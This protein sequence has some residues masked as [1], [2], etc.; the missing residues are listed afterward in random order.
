MLA[1]TAQVRTTALGKDSFQEADITGITMPVTKHNYLVK[2]VNDLPRVVA[3]ALYIAGT[4]RPGPVLIDVPMDVSLAEIDYQPVKEVKM[5]G[6]SPHV[7]I[8]ESQDRRGGRS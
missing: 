7:E 8:D 3:E 5:R 4:G 1:I 6:Y 2:D